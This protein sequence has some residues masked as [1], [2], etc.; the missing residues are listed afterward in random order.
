MLEDPQC[1]SIGNE[2]AQPARQEKEK[3]KAQ[4]VSEMEWNN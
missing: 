4:H 1:I 2:I 3:T